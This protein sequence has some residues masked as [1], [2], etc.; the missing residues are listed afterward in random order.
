[1]KGISKPALLHKERVT[2]LNPPK[3]EG[4]NFLTGCLGEIFII[5]FIKNVKFRQAAQGTFIVSD[6]E[7]KSKNKFYT[8]I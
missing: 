5:R 6:H 3:R 7:R 8:E 4:T 2:F 1:M